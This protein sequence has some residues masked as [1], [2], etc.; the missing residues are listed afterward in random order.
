M[1][2]SM[3][4]S[5]EVIVERRGRKD[6]ESSLDYPGKYP[7]RIADLDLLMVISF[8]GCANGR[9]TEYVYCISAYVCVPIWIAEDISSDASYI[10]FSAAV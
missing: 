9:G 7:A 1:F 5:V 4:M 3:R 8:V 2:D 10:L 6:M